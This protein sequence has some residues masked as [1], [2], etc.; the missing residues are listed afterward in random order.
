MSYDERM[1]KMRMQKISRG[2]PI[3]NALKI[4]GKSAL[5]EYDRVRSQ[6]RK[7][8]EARDKRIK[9]LEDRTLK[10]LFSTN[11]ATVVEAR[12]VCNRIARNISF[13]MS[14]EKQIAKLKTEL[15]TLEGK[16]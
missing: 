8:R 14:R 7:D 9:L 6:K 4:V 11:K 16:R 3:V 1:Q 15:S 2:T 10:F 12:I 13:R 5:T